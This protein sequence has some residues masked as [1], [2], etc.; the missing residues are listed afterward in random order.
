MFGPFIKQK[1]LPGMIGL[2][3]GASAL[4][5]GAAPLNSGITATGGTLVTY[6]DPGGVDWK[7]HYLS[8][9]HI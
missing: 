1:P 8:L 7:L 6:T 4:T 3:G 5:M 2:G 9:I